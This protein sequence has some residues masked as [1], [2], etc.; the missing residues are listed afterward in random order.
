MKTWK[1]VVQDY[2]LVPLER[3]HSKSLL[4]LKG[5]FFGSVTLLQAIFEQDND[6]A[7]SIFTNSP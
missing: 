7:Y 4:N 2:E 3:H 1:L 5:S 6:D